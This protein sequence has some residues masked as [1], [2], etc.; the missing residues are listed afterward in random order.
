[1]KILRCFL[2]LSL[3]LVAVPLHANDVTLFGGLQHQGKLTLSSGAQ[4]ASN[5]TFD[6]RNFGAFGI[7]IGHGRV[8]GGEHTFAY[9]PNFIESQTKAIIYNSNLLVQVPTPKVQPYVTA[10]F[11]GVF[12]SGDNIRDYGKKWAFNYGGGLKIFPTGP[13]GARFDVRGYSIPDIKTQTLTVGETLNIIEV[14]VG[15]VFKF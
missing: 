9:A 10:G 15:V 11:G 1:M 12:T 3:I 7:R 8:V 4:S 13:V 6:P 14:S 2:V 5:V